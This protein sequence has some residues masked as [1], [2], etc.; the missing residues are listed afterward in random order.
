MEIQKKGGREVLG[1]GTDVFRGCGSAAVGG[2]RL[3]VSELAS[4]SCW[5]LSAQ[6]LHFNEQNHVR[7][8]EA[9]KAD[10]L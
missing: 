4:F 2:K 1:R 6:L 3:W 10:R 5:G 7:F 8:S 9:S